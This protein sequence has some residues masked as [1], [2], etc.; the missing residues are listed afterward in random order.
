MPDSLIASTSAVKGFSTG[1]AFSTGAKSISA[2]LGAYAIFPKDEIDAGCGK[3]G[4]PPNERTLLKR[5]FMPHLYTDEQRQIR[6]Q[7]RRLLEE[8]YSGE[9][10]KMLL[11]TQGQYDGDFWRACRDMGWTAIAV[12]EA[13]GGLGLGPIE[14]GII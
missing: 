13:Y 11:T 1:K 5:A 4:D 6:S 14:L 3:A 9:R 2:A 7:A 10:L 8:S 12:P